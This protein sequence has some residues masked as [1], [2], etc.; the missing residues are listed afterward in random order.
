MRSLVVAVALLVVAGCAS[1]VPSAGPGDDA[2]SAAAGSDGSGAAPSWNVVAEEDFAF[3]A[4]DHPVAFEIPRTTSIRVEIEQTGQ[5]TNFGFEGPGDCD[6]A[7]GGLNSQTGRQTWSKECA[8]IPEGEHE[9][10]LSQD[11]GAASGHIRISAL[12]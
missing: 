3:T 9:I 6:H 12:L 2:G 11:A 8:G 4:R 10:V 7:R 5:T 1:R